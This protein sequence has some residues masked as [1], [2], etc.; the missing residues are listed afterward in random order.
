MEL[1]IRSMLVKY[2]G[3]G[4]NFSIFNLSSSTYLFLLVS[5][6]KGALFSH[7]VFVEYKNEHLYI[8]K[9]MPNIVKA[10]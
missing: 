1:R 8:L 7:M 2:R 4:I 6:T 10:H 3:V 9:I 5:S